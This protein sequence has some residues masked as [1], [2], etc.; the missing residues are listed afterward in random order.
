MYILVLLN[1]QGM[2]YM[3]VAIG[4]TF[5]Q[6]LSSNNRKGFLKDYIAAEQVQRDRL[7]A[8]TRISACQHSTFIILLPSL[9]TQAGLK[10]T[11]HY[12]A[13]VNRS[14]LLLP[15]CRPPQNNFTI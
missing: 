10:S 5:V 13:L 15:L 14:F 6:L 7:P 4:T 2:T 11:F 8:Q 3:A 1:W 12:H 9:S